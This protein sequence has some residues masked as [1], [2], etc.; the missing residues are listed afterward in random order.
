MS[1]SVASASSNE[2]DERYRLLVDAIT[3]YAIC[4]LD[5]TGIVS[6]WNAGA[7]RFKGYRAAEIIGQNFSLFYTPED[8][9][10]L[11]PEMAL[12]TAATEGH[13]EKEGW[14]V[15][16]DGT[17]FWAHVV[18][19]PIRNASGD[20]IGFAKITRDLTERKA[21][22][23]RLKETQ[24]QFRRLVEGVTDYAIYML[25]PE[26]YVTSWNSGAQRIKGY[27][28]TEIIGK[29]FSQF[30]TSEDRLDGAPQAGLETAR[31]EGRFEKEG[32]RLRKDGTRFRANAVIDAI[33]ND[34]GELIGFAKVTRDITVQYRAQQSLERAQQTLF[35]AQ[36][37]ESLG[38]LTGGIAHD[39]NNLL[40][41]VGASLEVLRKYLTDNPRAHMLLE[42]A[43]QGVERGASLTQRM[44][45]FARRQELELRSVDLVALVRGMTE[46]LER[47]IGPS[48]SIVTRLANDLPPVRTDANQLEAAILNLVVNARDAMPNGGSIVISA[49]AET[50]AEDNQA[51][52][53]V[54]DYVR[55]S[56][57]DCGQGMD[58]ATLAQAVEP[59][60]TTKGVG[61]GTGLGLAMVH[62]VAEQSG[63]KLKLES[64]PGAGTTAS[65]W[66]PVAA[67]EQDRS[68]DAQAT[69][70]EI[71][72]VTAVERPIVL[73]VDD[74]ALVRVS[75][76][77]MLDDIGYGVIEVEDAFRAL[78][79]IA[80][81][82][83]I[84]ILL[85]DQAMPGLTGLQLAEAAKKL[86]PR[87][88][89]I[90]A[91]GYAE[92][93]KHNQGILR[94]L[95]KPYRLAELLDAIAAGLEESV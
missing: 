54:G 31:R 6:S 77:A 15:R 80:S 48:I 49:R 75:T 43:M 53:I 73:V 82:T 89:I 9:A 63:G 36:K 1:V 12:R 45:A 28:P 11:R 40:T 8:R 66:L 23:E 65:L 29:H 88:P 32:W 72:V 64:K 91:S 60:F 81:P 51:G 78:E 57:A 16:K 85:T 70:K 55:L 41:A 62:G 14:R 35:Q 52:A 7:E 46:M 25:D 27:T 47:S 3:D 26:G 95:A 4:M 83:R 93:P 19:D 79:V 87:L 69:T 86:R 44:L 67:A 90:L 39:F 18:I 13:Y 33:R 84:S 5:P 68:R 59:F 76:C 61:K 94:R 58:E 74:D 30:Y 34:A 24:E 21:A 22:A 50:L 17:R 92:L 20:L 37:L 42:N 10:A 56:V 2:V 38:Q 71:P